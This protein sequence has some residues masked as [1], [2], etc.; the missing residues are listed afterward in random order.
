VGEN[1]RT[2]ERPDNE[3]GSRRY[4]GHLGLTVLDG[5]LHGDAQALPRCGCFCDIFA[6]LLRRLERQHNGQIAACASSD[7]GRRTRPRG[8]ILGASAD[9]APTSPPVARR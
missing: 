6:D 8:P 9:E 1:E 7:G 5:E 2:L 3:R 4:D